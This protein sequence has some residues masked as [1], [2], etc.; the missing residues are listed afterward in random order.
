MSRRSILL[1]LVAVV[2]IA[3]VLW[4]LG[5]GRTPGSTPEASATLP[6]VAPSTSVVADARV[7]P[8]RRAELTAPARA[9]TVA[10]VLATEGATVAAGAPLVRFDTTA[11]EA[12][13]AGA[14]AALD[15]ATAT[16]AQAAAAVDQAAAVV[17]ASTA[18][19]EEAKA[20]VTAADAQ[21]DGTPSGTRARR[22]ANAE[23]D[24]AQ[25][26]LDAARARRDVTRHARDA[27]EAAAEAATADVAR[28]KASLTAAETARDDLT[29]TAP[30]AG[31]VASLDARVGEVVAP[32]VIVARVAD[33]SGWRFET[34]DLDET[35]VGRIAE[36]A[37]A[38]VSL[39][40]FPDATIVGTVASIA[41][42]GTSSAGDIVFTVVI[43]PTGA[44]PD[45]LRWN[46]TASA[47][48]D[49]AASESS[50]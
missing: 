28:A 16:A 14:T 21:R 3:A 33:P 35:A 22:A 31:V 15:A 13:V 43:E 23:V 25:A 49:A 34:T 4:L 50:N 48:I 18:S 44:V 32:G 26:A 46:M 9:T 29:V 38:T 19:V 5:G 1:L 41:P 37:H 39:D 27:A 30:F 40:A 45:G 2:A 36:G 11:A 8:V 47:T 10:E 24:R 20:T 42:F 6:P 7:V 12:D 17:E